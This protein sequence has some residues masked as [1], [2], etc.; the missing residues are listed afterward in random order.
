MIN[1]LSLALL[2]GFVGVLET[3]S[4]NAGETLVGT[5]RADVTPSFPI[6]LGGYASRD[7]EAERIETRLSAK[8][9][10]IGSDEEGP[11]LLLMVDSLGVPEPVV[12][13]VYNR[14][15]KET[16]LPR[17]NFAVSSTH[18]H[19]APILR[20]TAPNLF[21]KKLA[22]D[23]EAHRDQYTEQLTRALESIA[24]Q[25]LADRRPANLAWG[26]GKV[27]F[28]INR[29]VL[30]DGKWTGFGEVPDGP[31]DHALPVLRAV[32]PDGTLRA[33]VTNYA[34]H[35]T[36][37]DPKDNT[38]SAD[39]AG[40]AQ[41]A[42][43]RQSPGCLALTIIGCAGDANPKNRTGASVAQKHGKRL[44]DEAA[45]V[46]IGSMVQLDGPPNCQ[47]RVVSLPF[48]T[49][50][51]REEL[52]RLASSKEAGA[53]NASTLLEKLDRGEALQSTLEYPVQTWSFGDKLCMVFLGGEVVVDYALRLKSEL[54]ASKLWISSYTNDVPCYIPSERIL[55][56]GG[57][58]A[59][60][61]MYYY[62]KPTRLKPGVE[63]RIVSAV[64]EVVPI[65][66]RK[67]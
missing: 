37:L 11:C 23:R 40:Y 15:A 35:C 24:L 14:I 55:R 64:E 19:S 28:A 63:D 33:V 29:R 17:A 53:Y 42:I 26:Q 32:N 67:R 2:F 5:A 25:A 18:T 39:W 16:K 12:T 62:A 31:V 46:M 49:L 44:A 52:K 30:K 56:E 13:E 43:E 3:G 20:S 57:Y 7:A 54:D 45:R 6:M 66:F 21:N 34:C 58:E 48:D 65:A 60:G 50:P 59:T 4:A 8:A 61:A 36:T 9:L 41:A 10:A 47:F 38:I 27:D 51:T 1:Q 22:G